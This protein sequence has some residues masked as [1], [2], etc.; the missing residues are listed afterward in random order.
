MNKR[1]KSQQC[2]VAD[3][4]YELH[5]SAVDEIGSKY[6][7]MSSSRYSDVMMVGGY[8][9]TQASN[10]IWR[11]DSTG[12]RFVKNR[13]TIDYDT[14]DLKEFMWVKLKAQPVK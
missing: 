3:F 11:E 12:V 8:K 4:Y 1:S 13:Y 2:V 6:Y 5:D 9:I 7:V 14:V 10:R